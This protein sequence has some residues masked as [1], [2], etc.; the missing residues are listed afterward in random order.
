MLVNGELSKSYSPPEVVKAH[1]SERSGA[2]NGS[3]KSRVINNDT[4]SHI[5][6]SIIRDSDYSK[7]VA[8]PYLLRGLSLKYGNILGI[9]KY[10]DNNKNRDNSVTITTMRLNFHTV[11]SL[12]KHYGKETSF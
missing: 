5:H 4:F 3:E 12:V 6:Y 10:C 11:T 1:A 8:H 7:I 2:F 9:L